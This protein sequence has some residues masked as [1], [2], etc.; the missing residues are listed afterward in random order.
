MSLRSPARRWL[1]PQSAKQSRRQREGGADESPTVAI[2]A[3][4]AAALLGFLFFRYAPKERVPPNKAGDAQR[5]TVVE[6]TPAASAQP[7]EPRPNE[8]NSLP[9][10]TRIEEDTGTAGHG[11]LTVENG[12]SEDAVARLSDAATDQ[13]V[14]WF[15]VKA[16]SSG[17]MSRIPQGTYKLAYTTGLNWVES[18][19]SFS[20]QPTYDEFERTLDYNEQRDPEGVKYHTIRVTL[21]SVLFGN[22][23]TRTI[24]REEFLRGHR[25]TPL[26]PESS[27]ATR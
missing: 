3:V 15:F 20:W 4:V 2:V 10:G 9:T 22:V 12:T 19:D 24:T 18:D 16:H 17:H 25:R 11:K 27:D 26:Q 14:R 1:R 21:N 5:S 23:R 13:T 7:V 8:Y 6:Q